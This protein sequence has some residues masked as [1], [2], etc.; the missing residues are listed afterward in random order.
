MHLPQNGT[1]GVDPRP[2]VCF[3]ENPFVSKRAE[4]PLGSHQ[5]LTFVS[6]A[7]LILG[8]QQPVPVFS[9]KSFGTALGLQSK[10]S[11]SLEL[12]FAS[13]G[14]K[15]DTRNR[16]WTFASA[17]QLRP[18]RRR[19]PQSGS[20]PWDAKDAALKEGWTLRQFKGFRVAHSPSE[21]ESFG[22]G[23]IKRTNGENLY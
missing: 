21:N 15:G 18:P 10:H 17:A 9:H 1:I 23:L 19:C 12:S 13:P 8:R 16:A 3:M 4:G 2:F 5:K 7:H 20:R 14:S 22:C 11:A 6:R